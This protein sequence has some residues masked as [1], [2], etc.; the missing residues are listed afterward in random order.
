MKESDP[1]WDVPASILEESVRNGRVQ[2]ARVPPG[3][4]NPL[5]AFW[6]GLSLP[7]IG[8]HGT[9]A[10]SSIFGAATHGC[11][12]MHHAAL[13]RL[14]A[15]VHV[16]THGRTIYEPVLMGTQ[17]SDVYLEVHPDIYRSGAGAPRDVARALA[18]AAGLSDRIDWRAADAVAEVRDGVAREI[19]KRVRPPL[20]GDSTP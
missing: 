9:V 1:T 13:A 14:F 4:G 19:T 20:Q 11:I 12:R 18:Q 6:I 10:P 7:G 5:G 8:I 2:P 16:G 17:D 15:S 3:P